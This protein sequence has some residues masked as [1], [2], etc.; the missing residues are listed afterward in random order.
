ME[1]MVALERV[2]FTMGDGIIV[3]APA[4]TSVR[5]TCGFEVGWQ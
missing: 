1:G 4:P 5:T 2:A 3:Y